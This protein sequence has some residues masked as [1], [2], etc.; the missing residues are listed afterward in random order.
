M[1]LQRVPSVSA[2]GPMAVP[3]MCRLVIRLSPASWAV[4]AC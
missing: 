1:T 4:K 3:Q 2:Q